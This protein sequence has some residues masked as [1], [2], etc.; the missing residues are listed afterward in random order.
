MWKCLSSYG[1]KLV[2]LRIARRRWYARGKFSDCSWA[3]AAAA[4]WYEVFLR[5]VLDDDLA[6]EQAARL[7]ART[8]ADAEDERHVLADVDQVDGELAQCRRVVPDVTEG[9]A[10]ELAAPAQSQRH[11]AQNGQELVAAAQRSRETRVAASP[12]AV[13]WSHAFW[14]TENFLETNLH[15]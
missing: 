12:H 9:E 4:V 11:P 14:F 13:D 5:L 1:K 15:S 6:E 2:D 7:A 10:G 3:V 8:D